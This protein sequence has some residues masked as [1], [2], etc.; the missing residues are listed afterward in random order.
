MR[1]TVLYLNGDSFPQSF[2]EKGRNVTSR[3]TA[4][5]LGI[6]LISSIVLGI[7]NSV[8]ALEKPDYLS[9][10]STIKT[11]ILLAALFQAAMAIAYVCIAV[12]LFPIVK[13]YSETLAIGYFG[14][15]IIAAAFLFVGIASLL[16][17]L[18]LS[19]GFVASDPPR[20]SYFKTIGELVRTGRD[21]MN[22]VGMI[23]PWSIGGLI[24]YYCF[25]RMKLVP[26]WLS[27][28]GLAGTSLTIVATLML[29]C[30]FIRIATPIYFI[31]NT[32]AAIFEVALAIYLFFKG[33]NPIVDLVRLHRRDNL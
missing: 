11:Q 23:L 5:A 19:Q 27:T 6:L 22:H 17:L 10:L 3:R 4:I 25:L 9:E 26:K 18:L 15:R 30:D 16:L 31:M 14:F 8:P 21:L 29:I 33:F 12:L 7:L 20:A 2:G 28:W 32:P 13:R 1:V 24:L